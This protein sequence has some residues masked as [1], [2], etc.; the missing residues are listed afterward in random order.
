M[1]PGR[2]WYLVLDF[3]ADLLQRFLLGFGEWQLGGDRVAL[4]HQGAALLL[5]QDQGPRPLKFLH[6]HAPKKEKKEEED[7]FVSVV[8]TQIMCFF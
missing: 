8:V 2:S 5:G 1:S 3:P 6:T 4:G 7:S